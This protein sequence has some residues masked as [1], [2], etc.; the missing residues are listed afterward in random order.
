MPHKPGRD[1]AKNGDCKCN[2]LEAS[3]HSPSSSYS[4]HYTEKPAAWRFARLWRAQ[5][6]QLLCWLRVSGVISLQYLAARWCRAGA[7]GAHAPRV[8]ASCRVCAQPLTHSAG[9]SGARAELSRRDFV[10]LGSDGSARM[11]ALAKRQLDGLFA[12]AGVNYGMGA[13][14]HKARQSM[15]AQVNALV[16]RC[17]RLPVRLPGV[18]SARVQSACPQ[19]ASWRADGPPCT[20][21]TLVLTQARRSPGEH[22]TRSATWISTEGLRRG[23]SLQLRTGCMPT[24]VES[25]SAATIRRLR[26]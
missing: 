23:W 26:H 10:P 11:T 13:K 8:R 12:A 6:W 2:K 7:L 21:H 4:I 22:R 19:R 3:L 15:L 18:S 25:I 16:V 20:A 9:R 14:K 5:C 24:I 17:M 1:A